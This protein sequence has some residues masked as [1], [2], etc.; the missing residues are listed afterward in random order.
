MDPILIAAISGVLGLVVAAF[1]AA[2]V[3]KQDQGSEKVR[4]ISEAI[5]EGA[6]AFLGCEYRILVIFVAVVAIILGIVP[7]LG[8]LVSAAFIF[9]AICSGLAGYIGMSIAIMA[10]SRTAAAVQ[11]S[12]KHGLRV[13]FRRGAVVGMCVVIRRPPVGRPACVTNGH[14]TLD[15]L[16]YEKFS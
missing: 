1:M 3:L 8:W 12:L 11:K 4:E 7:N 9:G 15:G 5:K 10:N 6:L 2:Y 16:R 13:S 14:L